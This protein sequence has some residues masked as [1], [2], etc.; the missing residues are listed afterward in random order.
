MVDILTTEVIDV[1]CI[2]LTID[3]MF[4]NPISNVPLDI[5]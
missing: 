1:F 4:D 3:T 2:P 5:K